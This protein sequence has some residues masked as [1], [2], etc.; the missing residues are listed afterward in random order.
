MTRARKRLFVI[1]ALAAGGVGFLAFATA[2]EGPGRTARLER[3][4]LVFEVEVEGELRAVDAVTVGPPGVPDIWNYKISMLVPEGAEVTEGQPVVGFD[5]TELAQ[6]LRE[7]TGE[8]DSAAKELEKR[9]SELEIER[10]DLELRLAEAEA[11]LRRK[12]LELE[13]PDDLVSRQ[14]LDAS[15]IEHALA[16]TEIGSLRDSLRHLER[17]SRAELSALRGKRDQAA[18]RVDELQR[19]LASMQVGAPRA[20]TVV[21]AT[22]QSGEKRKVG[23]SVWRADTILEIPDL[24][25]MMAEGRVDEADMGRLAPGQPVV[26]RLDAHPDH[27]FRGRVERI[28]KTVQRRSATDDT[29]VVEVE[30]ALSETDPERMRPGMRFRGTIE[31]G[32]VADVLCLPLEAV[33]ADPAGPRVE[34]DRAVGRTRVSPELGRRNAE[35]VE[36]LSGLEE[37]VRVVLP[38]GGGS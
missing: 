19:H 1:G 16:E 17:R 11:T 23:D 21:Y 7:K 2:D 4:D 25:R 24:T 20:G 36:V 26:I 31:V 22:T 32:R 27:A 29:K 13:V 28:A 33:V 30:L 8:R 34:L 15:R 6:N 3:R 5:T 14:E 38:G 35:C 18:R 10:Q 9:E 12:D 37:G